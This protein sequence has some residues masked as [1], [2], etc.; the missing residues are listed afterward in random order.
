[1]WAWVMPAPEQDKVLSSIKGELD[2][3]SQALGP[4][5][6]LIKSLKHSLEVVFVAPTA[7]FLPSP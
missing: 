4:R 3:R 5:Q 6:L 2:S 1:M 7:A